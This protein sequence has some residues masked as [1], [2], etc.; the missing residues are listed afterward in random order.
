LLAII[1]S[2]SQDNVAKRCTCGGN[3]TTNVVA[4]RIF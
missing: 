2:F 4:K 1:D 3:M